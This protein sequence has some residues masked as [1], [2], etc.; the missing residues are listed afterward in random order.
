[1]NRCTRFGATLALSTTTLFAPAAGHAA[2]ISSGSAEVR[3]TFLFDF[4]AGTDGVTP[5]SD[6]W[7]EQVD[8]TTRQLTST[9]NPSAWIALGAVPFASISESDLM[10]Y[11]YGNTPIP[12]PPASNLLDVNGVFAVRTVEGNYAKAVITDYD[13]GVAGRA[14]YDMHFFYELYS[15]RA[16]PEPTSWALAGVAL[17]L[18]VVTSRRRLTP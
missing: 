8:A 9:G 3:G 5:T 2:L 6:I 18:L 16:V 11:A 15:G 1:M 10:G 17:A 13:P 4:E 14:F 12:G 7:W